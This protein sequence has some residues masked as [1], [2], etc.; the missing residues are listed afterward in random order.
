[1]SSLSTPWLRLCLLMSTGLLMREQGC[2]PHS[3]VAYGMVIQHCISDTRPAQ[4]APRPV[5]RECLVGGPF[6]SLDRLDVL[7]ANKLPARRRGKGCQPKANA[8]IEAS[9]PDLSSS[10][11][12]RCLL[13]LVEGS[14][15]ACLQFMTRIRPPQH[16]HLSRAL[17][18]SISSTVATF[19]SN[20]HA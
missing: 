6:D 15:T 11:V 7:V 13:I 4:Q 8:M 16:R 10:A 18:W 2:S 20:P 1:M 5:R 17:R 14:H 12:T 19:G 9:V 3:E